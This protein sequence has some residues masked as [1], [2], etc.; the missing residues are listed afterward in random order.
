MPEFG[1]GPT[2]RILALK[3]Y[4][5]EAGPWNSNR[6][7]RY[8]LDDPL[9]TKLSN[10][11]LTNYLSTREG[12]CVTMPFLFAI[13][14]QRL[15]IDITVA[16]APLH[17]FVKYKEESGR[18]INLETT[19]GANPSRDVWY[20]EQMPMTDEAVANG[21]YLRALT[22]REAAA[23]MGVV[24]AEHYFEL[25]DFPKAK[26]IAGI[27]L[28]YV[29]KDVGMMTLR[30]AA[31]FREA[32]DTFLNKYRNEAE[33]PV[34]SR[35]QFAYLARSNK[36]WFSKAEDLGWREPPKEDQEQYLRRIEEAKKQERKP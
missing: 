32:R 3:K 6:I 2:T 7:Y 27:V 33:M 21:V 9:G 36:Y 19:S 12:N 10:K 16:T 14:G 26:V 8:D 25:K 30:G 24:L 34:E 1:P 20:R 13:L 31:D 28:S 18:W 35:S 5:Y 23:E 22:K 4:L 17:F 11:L 15:E 29:P